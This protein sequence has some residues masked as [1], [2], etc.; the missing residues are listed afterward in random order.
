MELTLKN[1]KTIMELQQF[2]CISKYQLKLGHVVKFVGPNSTTG[3]QDLAIYK[4]PSPLAIV[5][6]LTEDY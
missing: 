5:G 2:S 4:N 3:L 6:Y 1:K